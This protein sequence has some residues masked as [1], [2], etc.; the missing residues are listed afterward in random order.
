LNTLLAHLRN[1]L[2]AGIFAAIPIVICVYLARWVETNTRMLTQPLGF[3]FPG[4]GV[5]IVL[6]A[7]YLL[8]FIVTSFLG[9]YLLRQVD[10]LLALVPGL[11]LLI[12]A[13][14]DVLVVSPGKSGMY[15]QVVLVPQEGQQF[16]LG[17][18]SGRALPGDAERVCV[19]LPEIP[20]PFSGRLVVVRKADC[21]PMDLTVEEAMKYQLSSGNYLPPALGA[22]RA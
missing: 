5:L 8:G 18:T 15:N 21:V 10:R 11:N 3:H 19:F 13:W 6:V 12:Q 22:R 9:R 17:F 16:Q 7:L 2:L 1:K 20:N 14:K 4:L